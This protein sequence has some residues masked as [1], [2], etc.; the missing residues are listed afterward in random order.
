MLHLVEKFKIK[1]VVDKCFTFSQAE[2]AFDRMKEG[3]Q[4]GKITLIP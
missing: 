1:P 2:E 3:K 4:F